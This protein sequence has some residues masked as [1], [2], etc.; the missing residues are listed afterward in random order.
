MAEGDVTGGSPGDVEC[1]GIVDEAGVAVG[2]GNER[3]TSDPAGMACPAISTS[4][5]VVRGGSD[6]TTDSQRNSSS[7]A[8]STRAGSSRIISDGTGSAKCA[9]RSAGLP[10]LSRSSE[11]VWTISLIRGSSLRIRRTVNSGVSIRR[12]RVCSGGSN[13]IS[14]PARIVASSSAFICP[15]PANGVRALLNRAGSASTWRT[16]S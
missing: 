3:I 2:A 9:T 6:C 1:L 16:S 12:N 13:P 10:A 11:A 4:V 15:D 7:T 5:V 8:G 14:C